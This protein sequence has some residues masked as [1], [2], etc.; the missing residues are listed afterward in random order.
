MCQIPH[1]PS[2]PSP[3]HSPRLSTLWTP[4]TGLY[5][6]QNTTY[7]G[8]GSLP[9]YTPWNCKGTMYLSV[10]RVAKGS[11]MTCDEDKVQC[12]LHEKQRK[13]I[14]DTWISDKKKIVK[15][16]QKNMWQVNKVKICGWNR[17]TPTQPSPCYTLFGLWG[18]YPTQLQFLAITI[19]TK[20]R[21]R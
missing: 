2:P 15:I 13:N 21:T 20:T 11:C 16:S 18:E 3:P 10:Q 12:V 1:S 5:S 14:Q 7:E 9:F 8:G 19:K 17:I 6:E 4:V